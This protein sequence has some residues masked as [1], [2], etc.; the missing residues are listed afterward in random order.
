MLSEPDRGRE[1]GRPVDLTECL[2][3]RSVGEPDGLDGEGRLGRKG[4]GHHR[5]DLPG[6]LLPEAEEKL[7]GEEGA[8]ERGGRA[9]F[10]GGET[11]VHRVGT[12]PVGLARDRPGRDLELRHAYFLDP[13]GT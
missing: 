7:P 8:E 6:V 3:G 12:E 11:G 13:F 9:P 1:E 4:P 2:S 5:D 10:V